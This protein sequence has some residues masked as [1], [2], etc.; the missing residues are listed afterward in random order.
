MGKKFGFEASRFV[1]VF[2]VALVATIPIVLL[3]R[4]FGLPQPWHAVA[5]LAISAAFGA[6][7]LPEL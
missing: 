4:A 7:V 5:L 6:F 2:L 3:V 1:R